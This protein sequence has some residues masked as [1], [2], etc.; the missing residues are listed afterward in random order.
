MAPRHQ[1]ADQ[2]HQIRPIPHDPRTAAYWL[3]NEQVRRGDGFRSHNIKASPLVDKPK[4]AMRSKEAA[5]ARQVYDGSLGFR[6]AA[7]THRA[8]RVRP[9][10]IAGCALSR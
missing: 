2:R 9:G 8:G 1:T 5:L 4:G 10:N 6:C 3:I 7:S